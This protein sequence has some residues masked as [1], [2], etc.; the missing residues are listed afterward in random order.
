METTAIVPRESEPVRQAV[1]IISQRVVEI[2][3]HGNLT[4]QIVEKHVWRKE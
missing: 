2:W 1:T 3:D 4:R